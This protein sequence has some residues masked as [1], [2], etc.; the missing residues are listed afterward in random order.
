MM[1]LGASKPEPKQEAKKK[2]AAK[3]EEDEEDGEVGFG[4]FDDGD[5]FSYAAPVVKKYKL[6]FDS[7]V[8]H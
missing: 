2:G 4:L 3:Q 5:S 1:D 8:S 6:M 7:C